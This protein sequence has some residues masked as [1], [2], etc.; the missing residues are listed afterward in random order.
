ME[1]ELAW[2]AVLIAMENELTELETALHDK[3]E[4][5]D[6]EGRPRLDFGGLGVLPEYLLDRAAQLA[7]RTAA[8]ERE[9]VTAISHVGGEISSSARF[10]PRPAGVAPKMIDKAV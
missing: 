8:F 1:S 5:P 6:L 9:L 3:D 10:R 7:L 4:I 2:E